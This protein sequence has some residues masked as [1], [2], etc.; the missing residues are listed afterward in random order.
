ME[1]HV[2]LAT[3]CAPSEDVVAREIEDDIIIVA[4]VAGMGDADDQLCTVN[5]SGRATW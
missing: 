3:T 2:T 5:E 1:A 4:L